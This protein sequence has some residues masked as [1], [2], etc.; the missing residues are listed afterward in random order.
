MPPP[1]TQN[2]TFQPPPST[3]VKRPLA[4]FSPPPGSSV[5]SD[6]FVSRL[7]ERLGGRAVFKRRLVTT[8]LFFTLFIVLAC[9]KFIRDVNADRLDQVL[10]FRA[11]LTT[12]AE[13]V[14]RA[15]DSEIEWMDTA[16]ALQGSSQQKVNFA[17]RSRKVVGAAILNGNSQIL[18]ETRGAGQQLKALDRRNFPKGGITVDSLINDEGVATPVITRKAGDDFLVVALAPGTLIGKRLSLIHI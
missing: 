16:L 11:E 5:N 2:H 17:A 13:N 18:A 15:L 3:P 9:T 14:A 7:S 8:L 6:D 1:L 4:S 12:D 10:Q